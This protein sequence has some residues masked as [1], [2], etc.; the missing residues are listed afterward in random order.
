MTR[1]FI[2]K[3][4]VLKGS[5]IEKEDKQRCQVEKIF[6]SSLQVISLC[7]IGSTSFHPLIKHHAFK[8][9]HEGIRFLRRQVGHNKPTN[10]FP[11]H[12]G[13]NSLRKNIS[14]IKRLPSSGWKRIATSVFNMLGGRQKTLLGFWW[15]NISQST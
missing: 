7:F 9:T 12:L 11:N 4:V 13:C 3:A 5:R 6:Q 15:K 1:I 14:G 8:K 10:H 2:G